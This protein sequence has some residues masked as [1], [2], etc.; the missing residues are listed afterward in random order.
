MQ[1]FYGLDELRD[2]AAVAR[3]QAALLCRREILRHC[4]GRQFLDRAAQSLE[5]RFELDDTRRQRGRHRRS[6][7][8]KRR[9]Q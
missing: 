7:H 5:F 2:D 4:E 9:A 8:C 6:H 1:R 3:S